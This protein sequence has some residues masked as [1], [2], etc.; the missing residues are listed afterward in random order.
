MKLITLD[1]ESYYAPGFG[2][3][4]HTTEAYIRDPQF[5]EIGLAV[6][7]EDDAPVWFSGSYVDIANWLRQFDWEN[8]FV[9]AH[10]TRFDGAILRWRYNIRPKGWLDTL[11]M[12]RAILGPDQ[13]VSLASL[14]ER[15]GLGVKGTEVVDALGLRREDFTPEH[16]ARYGQYCCNDVDLTRALFYK[17]M[18]PGDLGV[19]FPNGFPKK[20][21]KLIDATLRMF[22]EPRLTLNTERLENHLEKVRAN[23]Q[24][25]LDATA[26]DKSV[27]MSNAQL[28]A[29]LESLGVEPPTKISKTTGKLTF[30]FAKTDEK[31]KE[32]LEHPDARVQALVAARLGVKSTLEETRTE[33][34]I[35]ISK[36]GL[37]PVPLRYYGA[38]TGRWAADDSINMQ[39]LPRKSPIKRAI[40]A[41]E[42][43]VIIGAD[44]SNIEL[45]V[46]LCIA[47]EDERLDLL[48]QGR[49]LYKDFAASVFGV[50]YDEV[51]DEQRF[52][53]K[54][55]QLSLIFGVGEVRL[56]AA[57]KTGSGKDIGETLS[58]DIV[59]LYRRTTAGVVQMWGK[60]DEVLKCMLR[61]NARTYGRD[62]MYK[63]DGSRGLLLPSGLY[64]QYPGLMFSTR[65]NWQ[66]K[67][68]SGMEH[69]YGAKV[70]QGTTQATARCVLSEQLLRIQARY[71]VA[72]T[73]HDALY[74]V[75]PEEQAEEARQFVQTVMTT[76]PE[77]LPMLPLGVE[78]K[79]GT[80][81]AL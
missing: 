41:P 52:I 8:S 18:L 20:E 68:R 69:L 1:W 72:L 44:L 63:V 39:N 28:A 64:L 76:P 2:F 40:E 67:T 21:L 81:L 62:G 53:G 74:I 78:I 4:S 7:V 30:A 32:L 25:L 33:R 51:D 70:F 6:A 77:W 80:T 11:S 60:G 58:Q 54:T 75:V 34:L 13:S 46:G 29:T 65:D 14:A 35:A 27:I 71:P 45:R 47:G 22:I 31:F 49:D 66:F 9:L 15:Y 5:Q 17:F 16:L 43:H 23:K 50:S 38:R 10:N 3:K 12:G 73:I 79:T 48:R 24:A 42:G 56:R 61:D 19:G 57:I 55:S 37:L 59:N 26:S 36:R